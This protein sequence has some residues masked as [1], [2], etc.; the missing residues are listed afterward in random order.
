MA[1]H[2]APA[3]HGAHDSHAHDSHAGGHASFKG[4]AIGFV[5][6]VIL[7]VIPFKIVMDGTMDQAQLLLKGMRENP[8]KYFVIRLKL[9]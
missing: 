3:A 1:Q 5:L 7:T 2:N 6:A 4:Y 9:F 8:K